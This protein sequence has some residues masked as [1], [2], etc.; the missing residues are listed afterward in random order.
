M[1][2]VLILILISVFSF[3]SQAAIV[4]QDT[5]MLSATVVD[6]VQEPLPYA[7]VLLITEE[8][9][10]LKSTTT[11]SKGVFN[12]SKE[13]TDGKFIAVRFMGYKQARVSIP[14]PTVIQLEPN[15]NTL[16]EVIV[17]GKRAVYK[18]S[19]GTFEIDVSKSELKKLPEVADV[20]AFLPGM[21][22]TGGRVV[23]ISGGTPLYI[24]NGV[25]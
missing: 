6:E 2:R 22:A 17:K 5:L 23:P 7:T 9:E 8:G 14:L 1:F 10:I 11:D 18:V 12:I 3:Q 13:G 20:L 25:E 15:S 24:L 21:L 4:P 16:Q 19:E